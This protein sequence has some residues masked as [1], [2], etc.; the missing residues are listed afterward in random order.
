MNELFL[1]ELKS[2]DKDLLQKLV[3]LEDHIFSG[4]TPDTMH[5][6]ESLD[7]LETIISQC[8]AVISEIE[9]PL[10]KAERYL[11][12]CIFNTYLLTV[13]GLVGLSLHTEFQKV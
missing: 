6:D 11:M 3:L 9:S 1:S 8:V 7:C 13:L 4:S 2:V 12:N 10:E 5:A